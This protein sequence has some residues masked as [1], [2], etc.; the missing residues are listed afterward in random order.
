MALLHMEV[1]SQ[2]LSLSASNKTT[3]GAL[4][5]KFS[6]QLKP[7]T[8]LFMRALA[9]LNFRPSSYRSQP[10]NHGRHLKPM[11]FLF[12][13]FSVSRVDQRT[14]VIMA[15]KHKSSTTARP[16]KVTWGGS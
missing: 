14:L 12:S 1:H 15:N 16:D 8:F 10:G 3:I 7:S 2:M 13:V 9:S 4:A 11:Q 6:V 5:P